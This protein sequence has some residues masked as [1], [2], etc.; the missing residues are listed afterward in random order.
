M[1]EWHN[2]ETF[3]KM[4][5]GK[6]QYHVIIKLLFTVRCQDSNMYT[7]TSAQLYCLQ[8]LRCICCVI[9]T[10]IMIANIFCIM[11]IAWNYR[12]PYWAMTHGLWLR[13]CKQ[14][15]GN[16]R[17]LQLHGWVQKSWSHAHI[18]PHDFM[19]TCGGARLP[20][21]QQFTIINS[22]PKFIAS[23]VSVCITAK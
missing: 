23:M 15:S 4:N 19:T 20:S 17:H 10:H 16:S 9:C 7:Y 3:G 2:H 14:W 12:Q 1:C 8:F 13:H 22:Q 6:F 11:W 21:A 5:G 18:T